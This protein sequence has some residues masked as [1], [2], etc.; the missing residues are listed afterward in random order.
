M[1]DGA[2]QTALHQQVAKALRGAEQALDKEQHRAR[3]RT[4]CCS[5]MQT[6]DAAVVVEEEKSR[7]KRTRMSNVA[8]MGG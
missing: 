1:A 5:R 4:T 8:F 3:K 6:V 2:R 7:P